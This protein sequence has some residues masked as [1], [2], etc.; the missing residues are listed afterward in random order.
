MNNYRRLSFVL[1]A[2]FLFSAF[3]SSVYA[4]SRLDA[5]QQLTKGQN[6]VSTNGEYR[7]SMQTDGNLVIYD[8]SNKALWNTKT[9][10]TDAAKLIMQADGNLVLYS[11]SSKPKWHTQTYNRANQGVYAQMQDDGNFVLYTAEKKAIWSSQT[12]QGGGAKQRS[13]DRDEFF[14]GMRS[15]FGSMN[16]SQVDGINFLLAKM[17]R[18]QLPAINNGAVWNRQIAY[19]FATIR[20]EVANRYQPITEFSNTTCRRYSGGCTYKGRG[21]VQ[22]THDYNYRKMSPVVGVD[23][24]ANPLKALEPNISYTITSY[25]MFNGSFT[26]RALGTYIKAGTTDYYNARR[27]VNGTDKASLINGYAEQFQSILDRSAS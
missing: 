17:E 21:Y 16:Q 26:G 15:S 1:S 14:S 6:L 22:L 23:L 11:D 4:A 27:V 18:D 24:V 13:V 8:A 10:G 25:G 20:H 19:M 2:A 12:A 5:G 7:L 3:S 9:Q